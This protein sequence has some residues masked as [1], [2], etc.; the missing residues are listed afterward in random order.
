MS[1]KFNTQRIL[2]YIPQGDGHNSEFAH[3]LIAAAE[4]IERLTFCLKKANDQAEKFEREYYLCVNEAE[5][6]SEVIE[7]LVPVLEILQ[8]RLETGCELKRQDGRFHLFDTNG[9][10]VCSSGVSVRQLL[11]NLIFTDC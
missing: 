8:D 5:K 11:V 1:Q 2:Q 3:D 10:P 9:E 6:L 4:E 7:E